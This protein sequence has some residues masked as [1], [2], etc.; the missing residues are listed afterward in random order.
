MFFLASRGYR[1]IAHDRRGHGRSSQPWDGND[2][3]TY[4]D[5]LAALVNA[6]GISEPSPRRAQLRR[7]K[8]YRAK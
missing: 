6:V 7:A 5:D 3:N 2:M 8:P 4:A 1:C